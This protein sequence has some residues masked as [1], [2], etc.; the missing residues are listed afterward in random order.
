MGGRNMK[1]KII[2]ILLCMILLSFTGISVMSSETSFN[3]NIILPETYFNDV[4]IPGC[5]DS[6]KPILRNNYYIT[7]NQ[8]EKEISTY[9]DDLVSLIQQ[10]DESIYLGYL[11][12]LTA[13]GPRVTGTPECDAAGEYIYNQ[14]DSMDLDVRYHYWEDNELYGN[15][16]EATYYGTD[17]NSDE[18]YIICAHYD[19]VPDSPG[20][21]DDGSGTAAVMSAAKLMRN[22]VYNHTIRFVTFSGEEQG[23]YGSYYYVQEAVQNN[24]NI[25][26]V[27]NVDMIGYAE[28]PD[29]ASK[30]KIYDDE[31]V[32][33]W[34]TD[35]IE[36]IAQEYYNIFGLDIIRAGWTWG[37]DHYYFWQAGYHAIF[38]AEYHFN[39]YYHSPDDIIENM[40]IPYAIKIS[41]LLIATLS[42]L[43]GFITLNAPYIPDMPNGPLNGKVGEVYTYSTATTDPQEDQISYL[44]NWGDGTDS[45]WLG[46]YLSG[47]T[48][49]ANH[50]WSKKGTY[51]IKVKAKDINGYES[52]W[53]DPLT[54]TMPRNRAIQNTMF[55]WFLEQF[56]LLNRLLTPLIK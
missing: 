7:I 39:E 14:F 4:P 53:S 12:N 2:S 9:N 16:I 19:S 3:P 31:D 48:A 41:K 26:A 23:L 6:E 42:E 5:L 45:E 22:A 43:S 29:D 37:S 18:I 47:E 20:A 28:T 56:P 36:V 34:I 30:A 54:V 13:F 8:P 55:Q 27:L 35:F 25:I 32:S 51:N 15:N 52:D 1:T 21:D 24:D 49:E 46:P 10:L 50:T 44:F 33:I 38:A 40:N 11:E 17:P